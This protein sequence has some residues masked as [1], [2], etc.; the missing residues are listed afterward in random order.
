M[1]AMS[2]PTGVTTPRP[3]IATRRFGAAAAPPLLTAV[4][5]SADPGAL[6]LRHGARKIREAFVPPRPIEFESAICTFAA[7]AVLGT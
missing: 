4:H 3:V 2:F 5:L 6:E 7:R 1:V